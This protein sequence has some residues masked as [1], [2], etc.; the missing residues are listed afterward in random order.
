MTLRVRLL[1]VAFL[2]LPLTCFWL[3]A[4]ADPVAGEV[5]GDAEINTFSIVA[6]DPEAQEWGVAVASKYLAVGS[7]VPWAKAKI[8]AVATQASVNVTLGPNGLD[9]LAKG[10]S[11][12]EVLT[13]LRES[14]KGI[15]SRQL[16]LV[17]AMGKSAAF[18]GKK[19]IPY[20]GHKTG[21]NYACQGNLLAGEAVVSDMAKAFET[22]K[23]K[24]A[25]RH[26]GRPGSGG[27]GRRRQARQAVGR[28]PRR[29]R[30]RRAQRL[31]R[32]L[33]R[34]AR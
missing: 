14:D 28:H 1:S 24:L 11:A 13:A 17:D 12:E 16:G 15:E 3:A 32:S 4:A 25:W 31:Q 30:R 8:G 6:Y 10:M 34:P 19:C 29:S 2:V 26:D 9:L 21:E 27:E 23:G 5:P 33:H 20:A 22:S 18:T 7:A